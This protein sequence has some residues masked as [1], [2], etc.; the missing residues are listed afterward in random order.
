MTLSQEILAK[1]IAEAAPEAD[2]INKILDI[3]DMSSNGAR[4]ATGVE[5][6]A[7]LAK[8]L[9]G[10]IATQTIDNLRTDLYG[11]GIRTFTE[12]NEETA[13]I[14]LVPIGTTGSPQPFQDGILLS[15][16][17]AGK[18]VQIL[19]FNSLTLWFKLETGDSRLAGRWQRI[20]AGIL[21]R[22][23]FHYDN[24]NA[25]NPTAQTKYYN[26]PAGA[27]SVIVRLR[28]AG[29][30]GGGAASSIV[31]AGEI[32]KGKPAGQSSVRRLLYSTLEPD[33]E[34]YLGGDFS[35]TANGG[36]AG[37]GGPQPTHFR[38]N[39]GGPLRY[40]PTTVDGA[41]ALPDA[42]PLRTATGPFSLPGLGE[43]GGISEKRFAKGGGTGPNQTNVAAIPQD[44]LAGDLTIGQ[45]KAFHRHAV[46]N[47]RLEITLAPG[48]RRHSAGNGTHGKGASV[49][50][51]VW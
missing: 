31:T 16:G 43:P 20:N 14:G 21:D 23:F 25:A 34:Q 6:M 27:N 28:G 9:L 17:G 24:N 47:G 36:R 40:N 13:G 38:N 48:G 3:T 4:F 15:F 11:S 18:K 41:T 7:R 1:V 44:G 8:N 22:R 45:F 46:S 49:E 37:N 29:G 51:I 42:P 30:G 33:I 39:L 32:P 10:D 35:I 12:I 19:A 50:I 26:I 5:S 2:T